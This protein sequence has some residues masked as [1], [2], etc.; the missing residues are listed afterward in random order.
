M[1]L[2]HSRWRTPGLLGNLAAAL[3]WLVIALPAAAADDRE[4]SDEQRAR[5]EARIEEVRGR[6]DLTDEQKAAL[7][8][9]LRD[10]FERR[11]EILRKHGVT[12]EGDERP[13]R[14]DARA[15]RRDLKA[16][17][18]RADAELGRILDGRQMEEY[19]KIQDETRVQM[20]EQ[21]RRRRSDSRP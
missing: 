11:I 18:E 21:A 8:P 7:G 10:D 3:A 17:R 14:G 15:L 12:R 9:V 19:R 2:T 16:A 6:L 13:S 1:T 4:L 20:R 5:L